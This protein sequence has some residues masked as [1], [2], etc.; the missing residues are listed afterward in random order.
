MS[1]V[2]ATDEEVTLHDVPPGMFE[3]LKRALPAKVLQY[4]ANREE[5]WLPTE[6][7]GL[8]WDS[9]EAL[10][11]ALGDHSLRHIYD[12][13]RLEIMMSPLEQHDWIKKFLGRMIEM[14]AF[15]L[16][17]EVKCVGSTTQ[18]RKGI[19]KG[20]EPD[21]GYYFASEP[22]VRGRRNRD[23]NLDPPLDL[24]VEVDITSNSQRRMEIYAAMR[25]GEVWHHDGT[26]L[27]FYRLAKNGGYVEATHSVTFPFIR[28]SDLMRFLKLL[29][30]LGE[31]TVMK[32]FVAW[33]R[34]EIRAQRKK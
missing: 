24:V 5:L 9:Y 4:S 19:K 1:S 25:V 28:A 15:L 29:D 23:S 6:V 17:V 32:R 8:S 11:E 16:D 2:A 34:K 30:D 12:G 27:S 33:A 20:A 3:K 21:E 13:G 14:L 31:T 18:R 22:K 26:R 7:Q 10:L